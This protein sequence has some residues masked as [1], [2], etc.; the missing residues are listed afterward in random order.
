VGVGLAGSIENDVDFDRWEYAIALGYAITENF[1]A[2]A[3]YR[4]SKTEFDD[5]KISGT[6][7][8]NGALPIPIQGKFDF[9]FEY[10]G[11]FV[12]TSYG[13]KLGT[14]AI[15]GT[16][17]A[18]FAIAYMDADVNGGGAQATATVPGITDPVQI[19]TTATGDDGDTVGVTVGLNWS[20]VTPVQGLS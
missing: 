2:Y 20:G 14:G 15:Q 9:D 19:N 1:V 6:L 8:A 5:V 16:L 7:L 17:A 10:D 12:G 13:W 4:K 18:N 11:P 3:G